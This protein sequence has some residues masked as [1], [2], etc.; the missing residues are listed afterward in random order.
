MS[1]GHRDSEES[2]WTQSCGSICRQTVNQKKEMNL[3]LCNKFIGQHNQV[4]KNK[5]VRAHYMLLTPWL[6]SVSIF[7]IVK[8]EVDREKRLLPPSSIHCRSGHPRS[9]VGSYI[10]H[11]RVSSPGG[12]GGESSSSD[13]ERIIKIMCRNKILVPDGWRWWVP[14]G[15]QVVVH[16]VSEHTAAQPLGQTGVNTIIVTNSS[17]NTALCKSHGQTLLYFFS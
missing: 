3:N 8:S 17:L 14:P 4:K 6:V 16:S 11:A 13:M 12:R 2:S 5:H 9:E 15:L 10:S 7:W 1:G